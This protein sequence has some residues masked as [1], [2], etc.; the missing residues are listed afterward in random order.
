MLVGFGEAPLHNLRRGSVT[1]AQAR[2]GFRLEVE[3]ECSFLRSVSRAGQVRLKIC[4]D[5]VGS[6]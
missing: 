5:D 2:F 6:G 1:V 4:S 3:V